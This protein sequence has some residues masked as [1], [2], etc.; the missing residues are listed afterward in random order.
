MPANRKTEQR[1]A[2]RAFLE[3][4][5]RPVRVDEI[6]EGAGQTVSGLGPATVY[7]AV[8][9]GV[10]DGWLREVAIPGV[11]ALAYEMSGK[12]HHH[13]FECR[14]CGRVYD[15]DGCPGRLAKLVPPGFEMFDHELILYGR[16][17]ECVA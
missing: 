13:H 17:A 3:R 4:V 15:V 5:G 16:C 9:A 7:R 1:D 2:I 14:D 11:R 8:K 12:G 6:V 10:Q